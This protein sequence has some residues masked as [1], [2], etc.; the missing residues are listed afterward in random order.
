MTMAPRRRSS[1]TLAWVAGCSHISVCMAGAYSTGHRAVSK[2]A[3]SRSPAI[4]AAA[5]ASRSAVAGATRTRSAACPIRTCGTSDT[6]V[7]T[8]VVTGW[9]DS[10]AQVASPTN[11][12]ASGVGTTRT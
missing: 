4:P 3:V 6:P 5:R 9:P 12:S 7:H 2:V 1:A 10:A 8:S 11:R